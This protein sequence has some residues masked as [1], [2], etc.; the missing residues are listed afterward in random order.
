MRP[1]SSTK[2]SAKEVH[3]VYAYQLPSDLW[4]VVRYSKNADGQVEKYMNIVDSF[5]NYLDKLD[6]DVK[7]V[8][9]NVK[10]VE[11]VFR[12]TTKHNNNNNSSS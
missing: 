1:S 5:T 11:T 7:T 8:S 12:L 4:F 9:V 3:D 2:L 6:K 10:G